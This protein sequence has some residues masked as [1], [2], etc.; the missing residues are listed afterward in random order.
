MAALALGSTLAFP[1]ARAESPNAAGPAVRA[2][3]TKLF[4]KKKYA[5]ACEK[6]RQATIAIPEDAALL[7][8][9]GLC[10]HKLGQDK[11]A[12]ATNLRAIE[13]VSRDAKS[14]DDPVA[15]RVRRH[16]YFNL[17]QANADADSI[18]AGNDEGTECESIKPAPACQRSFEVCGASASQGFRTRSYSRTMAKVARTRAV[19]RWTPGEISDHAFDDPT[20]GLGQ[21]PS[22]KPQVVDDDDSVIFTSAF[23]DEARTAGCDD[24]SGWRCETSDAVAAAAAACMKSGGA[25]GAGPPAPLDESACFKKV[26]ADLDKRPSKAVAREKRR[27]ARQVDACSGELVSGIG[28]NYSCS[29][30]YANAC[31][32]LIAVSCS[33]SQ[34]G[35]S[36]PS[37]ELD[38]YHFVPAAASGASGPS[39]RP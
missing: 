19:A 16:A 8:D 29:I 18:I 11:A 20:S 31:T 7:T 38:E 13:L 15:I 26:C 6:F 3:A 12:A 5:E 35:G 10:Q 25:G 37:T 27:A 34:P 9:L 17:D 21:P 4:K 1:V 30:V 36:G 33:S 28:S 39:G 32:G 22:E 23:E 24:V 14:I 2:E